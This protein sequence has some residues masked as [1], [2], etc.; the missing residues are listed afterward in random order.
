MSA[1]LIRLNSTLVANHQGEP[2]IFVK[3]VNFLTTVG[4]QVLAGNPMAPPEVQDLRRAACFACPLHDHA[5][6]KCRLC[7]CT[8]MIWKRS[9]ATASCPDG[10]WPAHEPGSIGSMIETAQGGSP[11]K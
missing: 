9:M 4:T 11:S 3:A 10:R 2:M 5:A 8:G 1:D 6:D 7:G